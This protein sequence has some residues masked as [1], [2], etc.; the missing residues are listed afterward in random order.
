MLAKAGAYTE[1]VAQV[2]LALGILVLI[3]WYSGLLKG[4][5]EAT[6]IHTSD[7]EEEDLEHIK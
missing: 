4:S 3:G 6:D 1:D 5:Q 2:A 7:C